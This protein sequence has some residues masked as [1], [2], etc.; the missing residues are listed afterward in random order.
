[1]R[2]QVVVLDDE[3][4]MDINLTEI[5]WQVHPAADPSAEFTD[6]KVIMGYCSS[7]QLGATFADNYVPGSIVTVYESSSQICAGSPDDWF[8][9]TLDTPFS[10]VQSEGNLIV[11]VQWSS[12]VD[13]KS[14]YTWG[15]DTG[16]IRAVAYT[17]AG[18]PTHPTGSLSSAISRLILTGSGMPLEHATFASIKACTGNL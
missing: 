17:G 4:G 2:Y 8:T 3:I 13:G 1:M 6:F 14:F 5:G 11:E 10:Y 15:W 12:P 7:D 18:A 9:I 16:T